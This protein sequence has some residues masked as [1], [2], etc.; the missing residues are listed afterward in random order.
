MHVKL[1]QRYQLSD[2]EHY[3]LLDKGTITLKPIYDLK[4]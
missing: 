2:Q 1:L 3:T 4:Y